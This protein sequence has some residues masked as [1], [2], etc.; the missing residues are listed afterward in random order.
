MSRIESENMSACVLK[1]IGIR[2]S[3]GVFQ[4]YVTTSFTYYNLHIGNTPTI[5]FTSTIKITQL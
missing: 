5:P 3:H 2:V 1:E 4:L